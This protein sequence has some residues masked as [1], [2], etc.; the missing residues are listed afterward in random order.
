[1]RNLNSFELIRFLPASEMTENR[2]YS[3]VSLYQALLS[4]KLAL[5]KKRTDP[6]HEEISYLLKAVL[7]YRFKA[8]NQ[9]GLGV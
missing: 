5:L 9:Y 2:H 8:K 3:K 7:I 6:V 1:M 4:E